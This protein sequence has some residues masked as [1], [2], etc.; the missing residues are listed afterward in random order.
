MD[1]IFYCFGWESWNVMFVV[2]QSDI[3]KYIWWYDMR[4]REKV[5]YLFFV[6]FDVI[7][8]VLKFGVW[9]E[10]LSNNEKFL[11]LDLLLLVFKL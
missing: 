2:V 5:I 4:W 6:I 1:F 7:I 10:D 9:G 8:W 11:L 3:I